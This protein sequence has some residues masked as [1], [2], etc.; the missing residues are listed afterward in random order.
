MCI[1][2]RHHRAKDITGLRV[3]FLTAI[4]YHGSD[5]KKSIWV[6]R[7]DCG[8]EVLL[9]ATELK[10]QLARGIV[11]SCGC[12][13][14]ETIG[15]KNSTHGMSQHPAFAVW[16]SMVDRCCL[17]PHQAW[18]NYGGRGISVCPRWRESFEEFWTDMGPTYLPGLTLDRVDNNAGYSPENCRW[19]GMKAQAGTSGT[20]PSWILRWAG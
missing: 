17:P 20:T 6:A 16:R 11:A 14:K 3:G 7:C 5:G 15:K 13:R 12:K 9:A 4:R 8:S 19:V 18:A 2:D 10:K 1:R